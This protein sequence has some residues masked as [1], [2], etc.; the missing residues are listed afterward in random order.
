[1]TVVRS[2]EDETLVVWPRLRFKLFEGSS[3]SNE[4]FVSSVNE[5]CCGAIHMSPSRAEKERD[6]ESPGCGF[7]LDSPLVALTDQSPVCHTC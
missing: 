1:M 2:A 4:D 3:P 6:C 7:F 5:N